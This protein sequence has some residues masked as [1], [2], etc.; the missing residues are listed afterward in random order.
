M[1]KRSDVQ[2]NPIAAA[3]AEPA[4]AR[5]PVAPA[6]PAPPAPTVDHAQIGQMQTAIGQ[7]AD[8]TAKLAWGIAAFKPPAPVTGMRAEVVRDDDGRM[9]SLVVTIL[10]GEK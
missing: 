3:P 1:L 2:K 7:L 8:T 5:A 6:P 4:S 9:K 10:R